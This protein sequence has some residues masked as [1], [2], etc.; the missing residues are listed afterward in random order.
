[1]RNSLMARSSSAVHPSDTRGSHWIFILVQGV[2]D[3]ESTKARSHLIFLRRHPSQCFMTL[4]LFRLLSSSPVMG[5]AVEALTLESM[6][7]SALLKA[8]FHWLATSVSNTCGASTKV[9]THSKISVGDQAEDGESLS[10]DVNCAGSS[11]AGTLSLATAFGLLLTTGVA[12]PS[13]SF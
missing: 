4:S 7:V 8:P 1:M 2:H 6:L 13:R 3:P 9:Y 5:P 11:G 12:F 10:I